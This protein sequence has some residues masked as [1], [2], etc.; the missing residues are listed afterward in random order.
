MVHDKKEKIFTVMVFINF[1]SDGKKCI[2]SDGAYFE[3]SNFIIV[4]N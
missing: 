1:P 2:T 3:L 4:P